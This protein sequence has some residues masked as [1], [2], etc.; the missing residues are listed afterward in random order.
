MAYPVDAA[1]EAAV[2]AG[3]IKTAD[4]V[5]LYLKDGDG[6]PLTLR[7]WTW[8]GGCSYPANDAVD[9]DDDVA[10]VSMCGR[11][12]LIKAIRLAA[13]LASE[14]LRMT[15][16]GSRSTDDADEV[17]KFV[18][19]DWHQAPMRVRQI[20][21]NFDTEAVGADPIWEWHGLLDHRELVQKAGDPATWE[22]TCQ[23]GLFRVRGRRLKTRSHADQQ[24]RSAGD[25]FY[26][27]TAGMVGRPLNW[28]KAP[29][30]VPGSSTGGAAGPGAGNWL[31][32]NRTDRQMD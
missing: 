32:N 4:L 10:Y 12:Q 1:F 20:L 5:D 24:L 16:D 11:I 25:K 2:A 21:L 18:D 28:A 22:V 23:G 31:I 27:G 13:T 3:K 19:A 9:D 26:I 6:D 15:L 29:G 7:W 8:T 14:P 30:N 17:G